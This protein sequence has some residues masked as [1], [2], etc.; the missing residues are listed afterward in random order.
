MQMPIRPSQVEIIRTS[1]G[2]TTFP[3]P[4]LMGMF[5][6]RVIGGSRPKADMRG[7]ECTPESCRSIAGHT[8]H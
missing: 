1:G 2:F 4:L 7:A 8:R 3:F 6:A 5:N